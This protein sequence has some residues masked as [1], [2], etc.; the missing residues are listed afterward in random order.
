MKE[1]QKHAPQRSEAR[2]H[3]LKHTADRYG[4][5]ITN[6]IKVQP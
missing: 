2:C 4:E 3:Q 5:L 6:I 1:L